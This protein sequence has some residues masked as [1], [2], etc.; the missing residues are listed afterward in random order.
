MAQLEE[1]YPKD[2][3]VIYRHYPLI[4]IHDKAALATQAAEAAGLQGKF[5]ELHELLF[6]LKI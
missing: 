5:W 4:S 1:E 6:S 2:L 3:Q